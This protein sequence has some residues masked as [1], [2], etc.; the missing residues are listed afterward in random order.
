MGEFLIRA[1]EHVEQLHAVAFR[2]AENA[3][4][5]TGIDRDRVADDDRAIIG[6]VARPG[7]AE[8]RVV[9]DVDHS[10]DGVPPKGVRR[11]LAPA[12]RGRKTRDIRAGVGNAERPGGVAARQIAE[13]LHAVLQRPAERRTV[14]RA[15]RS[16]GRDQA[17]CR[18]R[19]LVVVDEDAARHRPDRVQF[20]RLRLRDRAKRD[21]RPRKQATG[22][23]VPHAELP[24]DVPTPRCG[25]SRASY[26][27]VA[28]LYCKNSPCRRKAAAQPI[29]L[30]RLPCAMDRRCTRSNLTMLLRPRTNSPGV[31]PMMSLKSLM[32]WDWS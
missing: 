13:C 25:K 3:P 9:V 10:V 18:D 19:K 8:R 12:I 5:G 15:V 16:A 30:Y 17:V 11:Q 22:D 28:G 29:R 14:G 20:L 21:R 24:L 31:Q 23:I 7:C 2:P 1:F 6:D 32:K 27:R 26:R 4:D